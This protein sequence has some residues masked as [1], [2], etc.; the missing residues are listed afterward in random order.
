MTKLTNLIVLMI[1]IN[2]INVNAM[3][4]S[5]SIPA[6]VQNETDALLDHWH[7]I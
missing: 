4:M 5:M 1:N 6:V 2:G 7:V 3:S